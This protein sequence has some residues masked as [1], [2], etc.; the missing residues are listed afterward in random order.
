MRI[1]IKTK[2]YKGFTLMEVL[3][4]VAIT[5]LVVAGGFR[6]I[7]MSMRTLAEIQGERDLTSAAQK[8]WLNFKTDGEMPDSGKDGDVEWE[9]DFDTIKFEDLELPY[10]RVKISLRGRSMFIYLPQ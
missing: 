7:A 5:G 4:A 10:K 2:K 9:T 8:I 3:V 6:L 1:K